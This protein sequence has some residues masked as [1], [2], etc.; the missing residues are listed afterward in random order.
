M[1]LGYVT[2]GIFREEAAGQLNDLDTRYGIRREQDNAPSE[3]PV[4]YNHAGESRSF[5]HRL[6][7]VGRMADDFS[8]FLTRSFLHRPETQKQ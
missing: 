6:A 8:P 7:V 2:L 3:Y 5:G 1:E 4:W